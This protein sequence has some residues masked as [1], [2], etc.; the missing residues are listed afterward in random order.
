[1]DANIKPEDISELFDSWAKTGKA[2][3]MADGHFDAA[4]QGFAALEV[5]SGDRYL[6]IGCGNGYSVRWAAERGADAFGIDFAPSMITL[7]TE[8]TPESIKNTHFEA[9]DFENDPL[10]QTFDKIFTM[11][12][13]YYFKDIEKVA[14]H[15]LGM[16]APGGRLACLIDRYLENPESHDWPEKCGVDMHLLSEAQWLDTFSAPGFDTHTTH[17]F[18]DKTER[19]PDDAHGSGGAGTL[20]VIATRVK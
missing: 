15:T 20:A 2:H 16:L 10:Q 11:E 18:A 8:N 9:R 4:Q 7:A 6:D 19:T 13:F 1:M 3:S 12:V 14:K 17:Y 5:K